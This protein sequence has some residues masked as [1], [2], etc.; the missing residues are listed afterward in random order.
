M[1]ASLLIAAC[2]SD[3]A[4]PPPVLA[5]CVAPQGDVLT[6]AVGEYCAIDPAALQGPLKFPANASATDSAEYLLVPQSAT[7]TADANG[8]FTLHSATV[9][10]V[11][12]FPAS[13]PLFAV[14]SAT[15]QRFDAFL[16]RAE[17]SGVF[18]TP[19]RMAPAGP[20]RVPAPA[21]P[22]VVGEMRNFKICGD[23]SCSS[24][25][26]VTAIAKS[27]QAHIALFVDTLAPANGLTQ[28][29]L[30]SVA[31]LFASQLYAVD[32]TAFGRESDIDN[33]GVVIVLMTPRVNQLVSASACAASG[34]VA[35]FFFGYDITP[36]ADSRSNHGEIFYSLVADPSATL[37]CAHSVT[38]VK[39]LIPV[40]FIHEFQHMI[41][42]NQH[43]L[44]RRGPAEV[45][46]LNEGLSHFAEELG[47]R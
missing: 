2:K 30:D 42:F 8:P 17:A 39:H 31:T 29:D 45:L 22:P 32:T 20:A 21:A 11:A 38:S 4:G 37:S 26:T 18:G 16:R 33:N 27:V 46:W 35:G 43:V 19:E 28:A 5:S 12:P 6:L 10:P 23:L 24:F 14:R 40:T 44:V 36:G 7:G 13:N 3:S 25:P 34:F 1:W 41:S 47:G 15:A 9:T